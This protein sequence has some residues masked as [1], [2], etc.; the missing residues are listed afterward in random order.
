MN[1]ATTMRRLS[2]EAVV[3]TSARGLTRRRL[4]GNLG[5][6]GFGAALATASVARSPGVAHA[7]HIGDYNAGACGPAPVCA[8]W[9][10]NDGYNYQCDG[11]ETGV[12]YAYYRH[13]ES[14]C[15]SPSG[16]SNC[17]SE[18]G[19][20]CCDCCAHDAGVKVDRCTGCGTN[21]WKCI[22]EGAAC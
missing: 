11:A 2:P 14:W 13:G 1:L 20:W 3:A 18:G 4:L 21:W 16:T 8:C 7:G 22:C 10:C 6:V 9:R 5:G 17:W 19:Y 15:T 12:G